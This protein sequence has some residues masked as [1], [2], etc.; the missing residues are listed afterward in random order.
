MKS[1]VLVAIGVAVFVAV[2]I[3]CG[4]NNE[5]GDP[6]PDAGTQS[7]FDPGSRQFM[8]T[9]NEAVDCAV[10]AGAD[11][12]ICQLYQAKNAKFCTK[13]CTAATAAADCPSPS[14]GCNNMGVCKAP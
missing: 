14:P 2:G 10:P 1:P 3:G 11:V 12:V 9:C 5:G 8:E 13:S 7:G 6:D 4:T